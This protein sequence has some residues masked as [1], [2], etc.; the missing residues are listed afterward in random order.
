MISELEKM[1]QA[2]AL[3]FRVAESKYKTA[4][5]VASQAEILEEAEAVNAIATSRVFYE[6]GQQSSLKRLPVRLDTITYIPQLIR[7][8]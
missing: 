8:D 1:K 7:P 2:F 4:G 6:A 3:G 5:P